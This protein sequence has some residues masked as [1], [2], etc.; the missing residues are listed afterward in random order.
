MAL[1]AQSRN[2]TLRRLRGDE[3]ARARS[4]NKRS[5]RAPASGVR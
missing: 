3:G 2:D 4:P 5:D 1:S